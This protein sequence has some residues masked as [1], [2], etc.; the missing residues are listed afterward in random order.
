MTVSQRRLPA[1]IYWRR[2]L[3]LL[4][5]VIAVVWG[6]LRLTGDDD[7]DE[8][9][10][11]PTSTKTTTPSASPTPTPPPLPSVQIDGLVDVALVSAT[12]ACDP[13]KVRVT[14]TVKPHQL[15]KGPVEIGLVVSSAET[16]ACT[17]QPED[18][19]TIAVI[20]ANGTPIWD[21]TVCRVSLLTDPVQISPQWA[22][23]ATAQWTGRGSGSN[24]TTNEGYATPGKYTLQ[25]GTLGGEPG[26]TTFTLDPRPEPPKTS[27][28][29]ATPDP[30]AATPDP[31]AVTPDP[32]AVTPDPAAATQTPAPPKNTT[33][34]ADE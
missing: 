18:A 34:P 28:P 32:A 15:T 11:E 33:R 4:A 25:V 24:C 30:A 9:K 31:A 7:G 16:K 14:P 17:L 6:V 19:E 29:P 10:A 3:L 27:A 21:S 20:S 12:Q 8:P 26:K 22:T 2:R 5:V 23:L 13:E 1:E